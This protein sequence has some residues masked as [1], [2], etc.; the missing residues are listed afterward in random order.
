MKDAVNEITLTDNTQLKLLEESLPVPEQKGYDEFVELYRNRCS[1]PLKE[2]LAQRTHKALYNQDKHDPNGT[3]EKYMHIIE[4]RK[5][6]QLDVVDH[7]PV[8]PEEETFDKYCLSHM[9]G[10]D[11]YGHPIMY[12]RLGDI[13]VDELQKSMSSDHLI[14]FRGRNLDR[15]IRECGA[16]SKVLRR[17]I[18]RHIYV[19]DLEGLGRKHCSKATLDLLKAIF[20]LGLNYCPESLHRMYLINVPFFFRAMWSIVSAWIDED[21]KRKIFFLKDTKNSWSK[22][23]K[24]VCL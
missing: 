17:K 11:Y 18:H 19:L 22:Q 20:D 9:C 10:T 2:E 1:E 7:L 13:G 14:M 15:M 23:K 4:F 3:F 24:T 16:H 5:K 6:H 8:T 12:D 21:T